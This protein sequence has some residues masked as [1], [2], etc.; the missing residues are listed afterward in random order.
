MCILK[1]KTVKNHYG[2]TPPPPPP[3]PHPLGIL[4][5][6]IKFTNEV[7]NTYICILLAFTC[8]FMHM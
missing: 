7:V 4:V 6:Y 3:P 5:S 1:D 2:G 8:A